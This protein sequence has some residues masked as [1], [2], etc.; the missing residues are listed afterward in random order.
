MPRVKSNKPRKSIFDADYAPYGTFEG[1]YGNPDEWADAFK[2]TWNKNTKQD[3]LKTDSPYD[4]LQVKASATWDEIKSA[5]RKLIR[6]YHPDIKATGDE[7]MCKK[8]VAAYVTLEESGK[9]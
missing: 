3:I 4:I 5:Y 8:V 1:A 2:Q 6:I 7:E 9:Y